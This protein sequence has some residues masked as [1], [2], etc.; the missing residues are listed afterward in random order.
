M[1]IL[2]I[3]KAQRQ[4]HRPHHVETKQGHLTEVHCVMVVTHCVMVVSRGRGGRTGKG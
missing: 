3:I 2:V 1:I 4:D